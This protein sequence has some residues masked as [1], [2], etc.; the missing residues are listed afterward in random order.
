MS[1]P[2]FL[3]PVA[4]GAKCNPAQGQGGVVCV[5]ESAV[6]TDIH[7]TRV[8]EL[9]F[10]DGQELTEFDRRWSLLGEAPT[11]MPLL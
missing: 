2:R 7:D 9:S 8:R 3:S 10:N 6:G 11:L 4:G 1:T 5:T